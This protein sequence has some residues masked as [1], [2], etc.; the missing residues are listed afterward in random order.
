MQYMGDD[1]A[2]A[3]S[4]DQCQ[5]VHYNVSHERSLLLSIKS[6]EYEVTARGPVVGVVVY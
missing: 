4:H 6:V 3:L 1:T 2:T 5:C